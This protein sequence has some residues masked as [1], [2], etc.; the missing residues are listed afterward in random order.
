[1]TQRIRAFISIIISAVTLGLVI[2]YCI[3]WWMPTEVLDWII[4]VVMAVAGIS[5][6]YRIS[7]LAKI[8]GDKDEE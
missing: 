1:M 5:A 6:I 8:L 7:N 3:K 2:T 4:W